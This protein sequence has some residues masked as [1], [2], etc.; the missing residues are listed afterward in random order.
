MREGKRV[1]STEQRLT[2]FRSTRSVLDC[3]GRIRRIGGPARGMENSCSTVSRAGQN[4]NDGW[5]ITRS[6]RLHVKVAKFARSN[7]LPGAEDKVERL[8]ALFIF[9]ECVEIEYL[10]C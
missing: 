4:W 6:D 9:T 5:T 10:C 2:G 7:A 3:G 1:G 8:Q